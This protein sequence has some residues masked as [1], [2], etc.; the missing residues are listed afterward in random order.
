MKN[1]IITAIVVLAS[2]ISYSQA[3]IN[4]GSG[5]IYL[6]KNESSAEDLDGKRGGYFGNH[7]LGDDVQKKFDRFLQLYV[8]YESSGGAYAT[9]KKVIAKKDIYNSVQ[10]LDKYFKKTVRKDEVE[11]E[12]ARKR[13][14]HVLEVANAIRFYD[15]TQ[16]ELLVSTAKSIEQ[17]EKYYKSIKFESE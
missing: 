3:I 11:L 10:K 1:L 9:E 14:S 4:D 8:G 15:T 12:D 13:M 5:M 6:N 7:H 17:I 16:F 2:T